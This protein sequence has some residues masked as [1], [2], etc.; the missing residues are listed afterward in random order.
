MLSELQ[1]ILTGYEIHP[2]IKENHLDVWSVYETNQDFFMLTEGKEQ[3]Q[4]A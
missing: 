2:I 3:P 1:L 4:L